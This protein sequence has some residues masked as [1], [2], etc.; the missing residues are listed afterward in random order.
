MGASV[1]KRLLLTLL[2]LVF[3]SASVLPSCG[4]TIQH[5]AT[6]T[7]PMSNSCPDCVDNAP[8]TELV[9]MACGALACS[10]IVGL[11][12]RQMIA[13]PDVGKSVQLPRGADAM[14][15]ISLAPD[16]FPPKPIIRA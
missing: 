3:V 8:T 12:T 7:A 5:T 13:V 2:A 15:G 10:G 11:P 1:F 9:K 6:M 4:A 16:P 14:A